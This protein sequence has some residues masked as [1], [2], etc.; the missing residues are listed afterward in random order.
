ME[1]KDR[2]TLNFLV[3]NDDHPERGA[4]LKRVDGEGFYRDNRDLG[5]FESWYDNGQKNVCCQINKD[6][7]LHGLFEKWYENGQIKKRCTYKDGNK[8]GLYEL[9][10][11]SGLRVKAYTYKK[12]VLDGFYEHYVMRDSQ[13]HRIRGYYKD[14][15]GAGVFVEEGPSGLYRKNGELKIRKFYIANKKEDWIEE[16]WDNDGYLYRRTT[17]KN[18]KKEGSSELYHKNGQLKERRFYKNNEEDGLIQCWDEDGKRTECVMCISG[19]PIASKSH[20]N[21]KDSFGDQSYFEGLDDNIVQQTMKTESTV[22]EQ[23]EFDLDAFEKEVISEVLDSFVSQSSFRNSSFAEDLKD[24]FAEHMEGC[25]TL[26]EFPGDVSRYGCVNG[27]IGDFVYYEDTKKFY[28]EHSDDIERAIDESG[29][30]FR[31]DLPRYNSAT[32]LVAELFASELEDYINSLMLDVDLSELFEDKS[33]EDLLSISDGGG[34]QDISAAATETLTERISN[35]N[36]SIDE[37]LFVE[38]SSE[39]EVVEEA[40][41][42]ALENLMDSKGLTYEELA[43]IWSKSKIDRTCKR[44]ENCLLDGDYIKPEKVAEKKSKGMKL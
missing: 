39:S 15:L 4:I 36:L 16:L 28:D 31:L 27:A 21:P 43:K 23:K 12:G 13:Y 29:I 9:F 10:L 41:S 6:G 35:G 32:W 3:Q 26:S 40:A 24:I 33:I 37:L 19:K 18:G 22:M 14:G 2:E 8:D 42:V 11:E 30:D 20:I 5:F 25:N 7:A 17:F 44:A 38:G 1:E 34:I